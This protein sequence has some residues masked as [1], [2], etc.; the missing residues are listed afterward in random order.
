MRRWIL[1]IALLGGALARVLYFAEID[2]SPETS[3]PAMDA[4]FHDYWANALATGDWSPPEHFADPQIGCFPFFR[5]PGYP[6]FLAA[7][8]ALFGRSPQAAAAVQM[9]LGLL[10]AFLAF[11]AAR[12]WFGE[13]VGLVTAAGMGLA[14]S[15]VY[16]EGELLEPTLCVTLLLGFLSLWGRLLE[17]PW[18]AGA[19]AWALGCATGAILGLCALVRPNALALA[20]VLVGSL[21]LAARGRGG[22]RILSRASFFVLGLL[23]AI[24]PAAIRNY[25]VAGDFV[26][27]SSN[28][29]V[30]LR[31]GNCEGADG[32]TPRIPDL[33]RIAPLSGWTCFDAPRIHAGMERR[34]G[35]KL[36]ASEVSRI[37]ARE[38]FMFA[39][40]NPGAE[41]RL[42]ARKTALWFGPCEISNNRQLE[43]ARERS[44][45]LPRLVRFPW[46]LSLAAL[47][48]FTALWQRKGDP[49]QRRAVWLLLASFGVY[50]ASFL[51]FFVAGR[52]R[53]PALPMLLP[54]AGIGLSALVGAFRA[55]D[56]RRALRL[57]VAWIGLLGLSHLELFRYEPDLCQWHF[58]RGEAYRR[59]S[60]L[61]H[62][63]EEYELSI[64]A[65]P[66]SVKARVN[67][68]ALLLELGR[69]GE[70]IALLERAR[71]LAPSCLEAR[72]NL[73]SALAA[74]GRDLDAARELAAALELDPE[75]AGLREKL[76][77]VLLR[78]Q[79]PR[80]AALQF[81]RLRAKG[82]ASPR[83][84][85]LE[86]LARLDL[87]DRASARSLLEKAVATGAPLADSCV[88]LAEMLEA[89][90]DRDGAR[91][92]VRRAL[93][94]DPANRGAEQLARRLER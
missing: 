61:P 48:A 77:A 29:G 71:D 40:M 94:I 73:G 89:K 9:A 64:A 27:I 11:R 58:Q 66:D 70:S 22:R 78:A 15:L 83:S 43:I 26:A 7:I 32:Y 39:W 56:A 80:E 16:F 5:P 86:A 30:N 21:W 62:A 35:R 90:G 17:A 8:Y 14:W 47:G 34:E 25:V 93:A 10:N 65:D 24:A 20:P 4:A 57:A 19:P 88:L 76:G 92:L 42:L 44:S 49:R 81:E 33:D 79:R 75:N 51:P 84:L 63:I 31:I 38:A 74:A 13:G 82:T 72:A 54:L 67:L 18:D 55:R 60:D 2:D 59:L 37:F 46:I 68:G 41:L 85:H 52:Y 53:V 91:K 87:G 36:L 23:L 28:A 1:A 45:V 50:S 3:A 69:T 6:Y 12:K